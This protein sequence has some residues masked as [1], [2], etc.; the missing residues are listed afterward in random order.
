MSAWTLL[1]IYA[2]GSVLTALRLQWHYRF[3][4]DEF[5]RWYSDIVSATFWLYAISWPLFL[6]L[7]PQA[8]LSP[9]VSMFSSDGSRAEAARE[10]ARL[11]KHPPPCGNSIRFIAGADE[12]GEFIFAAADVEAAVAECLAELS[13]S[14]HGQ[15]AAILNW[16]RQ[17]DDSQTAP[18]DVPRVWGD[19]RNVAIR[20]LQRG[21]AHVRCRACNASFAF[22]QIT[23]DSPSVVGWVFTR[24]LC[25]HK[26]NLMTEETMHFHL[27]SDHPAGHTPT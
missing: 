27:H 18:S 26:H 10:R 23:H 8:L 1:Y 21:E 9:S 25:P 12:E 5:D 24:W 16:L 22:D 14:E 4:M 19:F 3:G 7:R 15:Y 13:A 17:R 2:G 20:L 6:V 11:A